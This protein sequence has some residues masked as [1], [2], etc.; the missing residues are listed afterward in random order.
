[1]PS[2]FYYLCV[3]VVWRVRANG[4][5]LSSVVQL[6][7]PGGGPDKPDRAAR[8][9]CHLCHFSDTSRDGQSRAEMAEGP[10]P[11]LSWDFGR[12]SHSSGAFP[13]ALQRRP[14]APHTSP[15]LCPAPR[16]PPLT[17]PTQ[18][19]R[20]G[21]AAP[22]T[23]RPCGSR[24]PPGP[25]PVLQRQ[26]DRS[27]PPGPAHPA[28]GQPRDHP[29]GSRSHPRAPLTLQGRRLSAS[30]WLLTLANRKLPRSPPSAARQ[31]G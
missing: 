7:N 5:L 29:A 25:L 30:D 3:F 15:G 8:T 27:I 28:P 21:M 31:Q 1:M 17:S 23:G 24:R 4:A 19:E 10:A 22:G 20:S 16:S 2:V 13:A 18:P 12:A 26:I 14:P 9:G 6:D 11:S